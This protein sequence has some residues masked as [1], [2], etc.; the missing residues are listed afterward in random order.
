MLI[1][2]TV[3][4]LNAKREG[5]DINTIKNY[6]YDVEQVLVKKGDICC[7]YN[8]ISNNVMKDALIEKVNTGIWHDV[9]EIK[10]KHV[11]STLIDMRLSDGKNIRVSVCGFPC[12]AVE[13]RLVAV[14]ASLY[15]ALLE[16]GACE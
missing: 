13:G 9:C 6:F 7:K 8:A 11:F 2:S 16:G 10:S 4:Y 14:D 5:G 12:I 15:W 3:F 1:F